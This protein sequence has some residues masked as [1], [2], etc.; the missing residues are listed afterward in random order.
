M[1][2]GTIDVPNDPRGESNFFRER[3]LDIID[4]SRKSFT[5]PATSVENF[6]L[7]KWTFLC[8]Y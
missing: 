6:V 7:I 2:N 5:L 3:M 4:P 8:Y 1:K